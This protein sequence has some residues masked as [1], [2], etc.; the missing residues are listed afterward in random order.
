MSMNAYQ[1]YAKRLN[2]YCTFYVMLL[3]VK[4]TSVFSLSLIFAVQK[5][6]I[7]LWTVCDC[8]AADSPE[9]LNLHLF[10]LLFQVCTSYFVIW[11]HMVA[12]L[13]WSTLKV[14]CFAHFGLWTC[15]VIIVYRICIFSKLYIY[16]H[17]FCSLIV[18]VKCSVLTCRLYPHLSGKKLWNDTLTKWNLPAVYKSFDC[19][20][21]CSV[22]GLCPLKV[23]RE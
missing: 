8:Y 21:L 16:L 19:S 10:A 11:Q 22:P 9:S 15:V 17:I 20:Y 18:M 14:F 4:L 2:R 3:Q 13:C 7:M 23:L 12:R 6:F 1:K 5:L